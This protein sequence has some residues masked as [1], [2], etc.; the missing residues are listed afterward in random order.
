MTHEVHA[1]LALQGRGETKLQHATPEA[2]RRRPPPFSHCSGVIASK[3][4][5]IRRTRKGSGNDEPCGTSAMRRQQ[6]LTHGGNAGAA[7]VAGARLCVTAGCTPHVSWLIIVSSAPGLIP[8]TVSNMDNSRIYLWRWEVDTG[9]RLDTL[10]EMA[11]KLPSGNV[12]PA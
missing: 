5:G 12:M 11:R 9:T 2:L 1:W 6:T 4:D 7:G 10:E 3:T 8:G